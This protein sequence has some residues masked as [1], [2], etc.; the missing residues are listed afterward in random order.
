MAQSVDVATLLITQGVAVRSGY[1]C[2]EPI[3]VSQV[4][5]GVLRASFGIY[6]TQDD[7]DRLI[8]ALNKVMAIL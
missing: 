4:G 5:R 8:D 3:L 2:A 1:L 6:T 7:I